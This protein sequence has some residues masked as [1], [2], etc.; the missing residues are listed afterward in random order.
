M[1]GGILRD[2]VMIFALITLFFLRTK[3]ISNSYD[4]EVDY[5]YF[6]VRDDERRC[7]LDYFYIP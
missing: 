6:R 3:V 7:L 4:M 1:A 5:M 2:P